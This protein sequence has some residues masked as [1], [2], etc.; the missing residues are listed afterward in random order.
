MSQNEKHT[1]TTV[2]TTSDVMYA[3]F[4][5]M[6]ATINGS[7]QVAL[8]WA[9]ND[10]THAVNNGTT[11]AT[12]AGSVTAASYFDAANSF[13]VVEPATAMPNGSRWQLQV[14]RTGTGNT[15]LFCKFASRGGWTSGT[16]VFAN[17]AGQPTTGNI[18]AFNAGAPGTN[19]RCLVSICNMDTYGSSTSYA[20]IRMIV[21][22]QTTPA[23]TKT[24]YCGGYIPFDQANNTTPCCLLVGQIATAS[25]GVAQGTISKSW[26]WTTTGANCLNRIAPDYAGTQTNLN[27]A[28]YGYMKS[29]DPSL[30]AGNLGPSGE[31]VEFPM[32]M[33]SIDDAAFYGYFGKYTMFGGDV[34]RTMA[35]RDSTQKY[36]IFYDTV[37]RFDPTA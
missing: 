29:V 36:L 8:R 16:K 14:T 17:G 3:I 21:W 26:G 23:A 30:A 18:D 28:G 2:T 13:L 37:V 12:N 33:Y 5:A 15:N 7:V 31:W 11:Y 9:D 20:Y 1:K 24:F 4:T 22:D 35:T 34:T 27:T 32:Y 19:K 6:T 10:I 25:S